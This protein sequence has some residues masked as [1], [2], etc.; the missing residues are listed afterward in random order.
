MKVDL[1][2]IEGRPIGYNLVPENPDDQD[3]L[4]VIQSLHFLADS[5]SKSIMYDGIT[6]DKQDK[7]DCMYFIQRQFAT[8]PPESEI[9]QAI[10]KASNKYT[11][12]VK[13]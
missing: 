11:P 5:R 3:K 7:P 10:L 6:S 9:K 2:L 13:P 1:I 12:E 4:K 8:L